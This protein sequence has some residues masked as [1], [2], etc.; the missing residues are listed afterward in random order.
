MYFSD[1]FGI[2]DPEAHEWFDQLLESDTRLFC[3]PF[4]IFKEP[5]NSSWGDAHDE[6]INYFQ[7]CFQILAGHESNE[8]SLQYRKVVQL[9]WYP[10]PEEFGLGFVGTGRSGAGTGRGFAKRIT[11]AMAEA[12]TRGLQDMRHFEELG[13]LVDKIGRDR[14]S[15]ITLNILKPR[16]ITYTEDLSL[17]LGLPTSTVPVKHAAFDPVRRRWEE[18]EHQLPVNPISGLPLLLIPKR[19]L[20]RLPALNSDA[21]WEWVEPQLRDDLNLHL[22]ERLRK[23]DI[24]RKARQHTDLLREWSSQQEDAPAEPYPVDRD[25]EGVHNWQARTK[26]VASRFPLDFAQ[27]VD[28]DVALGHFLRSIVSAF[29]HAVEEEGLWRLLYNDDTR[30]PKRE[31]AVQL[32]FKGVVQSYCRAHGVWLDREIQLGRG[33]V[34][35]VLTAGL[36]R[37]LMEI[38][39]MSNSDYWNGLERQL[40]SY[41]K[42]DNCNSGW[43]LAVRYR[44][45]DMQHKR[46]VSLP[47]R[48]RRAAQLTGFLLESEWIDARPKLS[49]SN[50]TDS[51]I[52]S[53]ES[54]KDPETGD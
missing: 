15:D 27:A 25:P 38:K 40:T 8:D 19:F 49:A 14:I 53:A 34:D 10:E 24:I 21:W 35:F 36:A 45:T 30:K 47:S 41:L 31:E 46:T 26:D 5:E 11:N 3:D 44:D 12:I 43:F 20:R 4:Q 54:L 16:F 48:T 17:E 18:R 13:L 22:N 2:G 37:T 51:D 6:L 9:M 29:K 7:Y 50:L 39:K 23:E 1:H 32:L 52:E 33:P 28:S 42:S